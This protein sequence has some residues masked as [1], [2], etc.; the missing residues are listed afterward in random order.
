MKRAEAIRLALYQI[1][2]QKLKSFFAVI[3]V[4]IG[5]MFLIT[6]VSVVEGMNRY[7]EEDFANAVFGINTLTV[8]RMPAVQ[9]DGDP[10]TWRAL[11][12][13][14]LLSRGDAEAI[15]AGLTVPAMVGMQNDGGGRV[16]RGEEKGTEAHGE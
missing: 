13:R 9:M 11:I 6:V 1:R 15:R 10:D 7:I 16:V 12:R 3:G 2:A 4:I 5:V 14:P 8:Q